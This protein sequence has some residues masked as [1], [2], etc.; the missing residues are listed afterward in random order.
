MSGDYLSNLMRGSDKIKEKTLI[1]FSNA[2]AFDKA[3]QE[4]ENK[5]V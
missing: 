5:K 1:D 2:N 3:L 4:L